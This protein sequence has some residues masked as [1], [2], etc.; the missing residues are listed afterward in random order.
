MK[1]LLPAFLVAVILMSFI[2][3]CAKKSPRETGSKPKPTSTRKKL[4]LSALKPLD[5]VPARKVAE[6]AGGRVVYGQDTGVAEAKYDIKLPS[7][8]SKY[9]MLKFESAVGDRHFL[10]TKERKKEIEKLNGLWD[11]AYFLPSAMPDGPA[12]VYVV[13][14]DLEMKIQGYGDAKDVL[15]GIAKA[16]VA[17]LK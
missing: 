13:R 8:K 4:D 12:Y 1:K 11:R 14:D 17:K 7:G 2:S 6:I 9:Y 3:A 16:A 5:I 15:V 10:L